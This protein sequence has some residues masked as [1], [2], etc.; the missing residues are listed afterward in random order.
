MKVIHG[1]HAEDFETTEYKSCPVCGAVCFADMEVCFGCLHRFDGKTPSRAE[2]QDTIDR[3]IEPKIE[4][5]RPL[6]QETSASENERPPALS[7]I[8]ERSVAS[9]Q[10]ASGNAREPEA[11][12]PEHIAPCSCTCET[13]KGEEGLTTH[14]ICAAEDGKRFEIAITVKLV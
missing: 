3:I 2:L 4:R 11:P 13:Q 10:D 7:S 8:P 1:S 6:D 9:S 12:E 5:S 14:H